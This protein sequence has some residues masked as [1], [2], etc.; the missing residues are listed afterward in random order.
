[1]HLSYVVKELNIYRS[2]FSS[3]TI[4]QIQIYLW[5]K[6]YRSSDEGRS[7]NSKRPSCSPLLTQIVNNWILDELCHMASPYLAI[8]HGK[9]NYISQTSTSHVGLLTKSY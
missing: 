5:I 3:V 7:S 1:M 4:I 8:L 2:L 6:M 9:T